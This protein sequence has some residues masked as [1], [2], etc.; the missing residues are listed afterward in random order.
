MPRIELS[1]YGRDGQPRTFGSASPSVTIG[2]DPGCDL[3]LP[4]LAPVEATVYLSVEGY[5]ARD[6]SGAV[7]VNG[8]PGDGL[9][10]PGDVLA[11]G[12][13]LG[14]RFD[15]VSDRPAP[16]P[17]NPEPGTRAQETEPVAGSRPH[18]PGLATFASVV[19]PGSGQAYN[20]QP[21]KGVLLLLTSPL[22]LPWLIAVLD[23]RAVAR[24]IEA[25]GGRV[26]RGGLGWIVL[27]LWLMLNV[28]LT[29]LLALTVTG[30]LP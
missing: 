20:G 3:S 28:A 10:R 1:Y 25:S 21:Y 6:H 26:G 23:A 29:A 27:H 24:R 8:V 30:V 19:A 11:V 16:A 4:G 7:T 14:L 5:Y 22:L 13:W 15:V 2:S 18:R 12:G 9:V 17:A